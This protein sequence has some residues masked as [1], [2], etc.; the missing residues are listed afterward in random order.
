MLALLLGGGVVNYWL[1]KMATDKRT[2]AWK[3]FTE[4]QQ[5]VREAQ[6][7][8]DYHALLQKNRDNAQIFPW[9][10][11]MLANHAASTE[12]TEAMDMLHGELA[13]LSTNNALSGINLQKNGQTKLVGIS[14]IPI[15]GNKILDTFLGLPNEALAELQCEIK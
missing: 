14:T 3:K 9:I 8:A 7:V 10:V 13:S 4:A 15:T 6:S 12:N 1:P 5:N 2:G 11:A